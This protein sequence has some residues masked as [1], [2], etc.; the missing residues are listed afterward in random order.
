LWRS[1]QMPVA[2]KGEAC[3]DS[4]IRRAGTD[5]SGAGLEELKYAPSPLIRWEASKASSM[6][7][8]AYL[9]LLSQNLTRFQCNEVHPVCGSCQRHNVPCVYTNTGIKAPIEHEPQST[10][11][12]PLER[13]PTHSDIVRPE[14]EERRLLELRLLHQWMTKSGLSF[15]GCH[16]KF[17]RDAMILSIPNKAMRH[18]A[19]LYTLFAFSAIH[20]ARSST[21]PSERREFM[22]SHHLYLDL[23]LQE[24]RRDIENLGQDNADAVCIT[25]SLIRNCMQ[26]EVQDRPL[27]PYSPPS[28]WLHMMQGSGD[29][30]KTAW[31]WVGED[32]DSLARIIAKSGPDLTNFAEMFSS[33]NREPFSHLLHRSPEDEANEPWDLQIQEAYERPVCYIGGIHIA[34]NKGEEASHTFR[35]LLA[36]PMFVPKLYIKLIEE[37]RPRALVVLAHFFAFLA[38]PRD[39]WWVGDTGRR[40]IRAIN[41]VLEGKWAEMLDWP[42]A[43]MEVKIDL[44]P[45][46]YN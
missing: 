35:R 29:V 40:E 31:D 32:T 41:S 5:A 28:Q 37:R 22:D 16:D 6:A 27:H 43:A 17:F 25:S 24:H 33:A 26:A 46:E 8:T 38:G 20:I 15:P 11:K 34:L 3:R 39:L 13:D 7:L 44:P 21:S 2:Q 1:H 45:W 36:F 42:L 19:Y 12:A 9:D 23:A 14:S 18:P 30:F 4:R 10:V